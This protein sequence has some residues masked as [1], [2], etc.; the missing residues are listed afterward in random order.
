LPQRGAPV[1]DARCKKDQATEKRLS[2]LLADAPPIV[3]ER[4]GPCVH[5]HARA[6]QSENRAAEQGAGS[7]QDRYCPLQHP[8]GAGVT[9]PLIVEH[10]IC[11][12]FWWIVSHRASKPRR[13]LLLYSRPGGGGNGVCGGGQ[14]MNLMI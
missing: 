9:R 14:F 7:K 5:Q 3:C 8:R 6:G 10:S 1:P 4:T 2:P 12:N 11:S 13:S